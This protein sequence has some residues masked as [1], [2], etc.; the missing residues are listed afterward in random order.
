MKKHIDI[1]LSSDDN[2]SMPLA[3]LITSIAYSKNEDTTVTIYIV[4]DGISSPNKIKINTLYKSDFKIVFLEI[5]NLSDLSINSEI[6]DASYLSVAMYYRLYSTKL[7]PESLHRVLYLDC[8]MIVCQD[9]WEL[10]S[11]DFED[12]YAIG[13]RDVF[14]EECCLRLDLNQYVNSG[15][16]LVNLDKWRENDLITQFEKYSKDNSRLIKWPDQDIING[17]CLEKIKIVDS[18]WNV[19]TGTDITHEQQNILAR[20]AGIIHYISIK[21]PW[22][23]GI[24]HPF[25]NQFQLNLSRSPFNELHFSRTAYILNTINQKQITKKIQQGL[26]PDYSMRKKLF[27]MIYNVWINFLLNSKYTALKK[28]N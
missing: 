12:K 5:P 11:M 8:D 18:K 3:T 24:F 21:K 26:M 16:L 23:I 17:T 14:E 28:T 19:Q 9:L 1:L 7:L 22:K 6:I 2:Y 4:D 25:F 20:N 15:M 27:L 13:V 10:Y